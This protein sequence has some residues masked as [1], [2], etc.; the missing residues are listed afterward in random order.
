MHTK[1][2]PF[3]YSYN[4]HRVLRNEAERYYEEKGERDSF[5]EEVGLRVARALEAKGAELPPELEQYSS[6]NLLKFRKKE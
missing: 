6:K 3:L 5:K 4:I 1:R 2:T